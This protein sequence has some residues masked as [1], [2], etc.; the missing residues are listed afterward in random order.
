MDIGRKIVRYDSSTETKKRIN[1]LITLLHKSALGSPDISNHKTAYLS[2]LD[3]L[4]IECN[5][6]LDP[7]EKGT[8]KIIDTKLAEAKKK[9]N[10]DINRPLIGLRFN[11]KINPKY[12]LA[13]DEIMKE[14]RSFEILLMGYLD[15]H[16]FLLR[17][18]DTQ[19]KPH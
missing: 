16:N 11:R 18:E 13:W 4:Y 9:W 14:A 8:L 7:K 1:A 15:K 5:A 10:V 19:R 17:E 3:R 6:K 12:I 2:A